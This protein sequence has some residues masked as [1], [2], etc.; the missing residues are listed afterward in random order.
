MA[1][2][3]MGGDEAGQFAD[4]RYVPSLVPHPETFYERLAQELG[5]EP[6]TGVPRDRR[7]GSTL[8]QPPEARQVRHF[9]KLHALR[10]RQAFFASS[11]GLREPK[12]RKANPSLVERVDLQPVHALAQ[13]PTLEALRS[14][15]ALELDL[16]AEHFN[17]CNVNLY[18]AGDESKLGAHADQD[19][20][21][22]GSHVIA[23][24]VT[25][26][27]AATAAR[28]RFYVLK[29]KDAGKRAAVLKA[30]TQMAQMPACA[31]VFPRMAK[32]TW[33]CP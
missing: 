23:A 3:T 5:F 22:P 32:E 20:G 8:F 26:M 1:A 14:L 30:R 24:S 11:A 4:W 19:H 6:L 28:R 10:F 25:L 2:A 12:L 21:D 27:P 18:A 17:Y 7:D 16:P 15:V 33:R 13:C 31:R 9:G 29:L